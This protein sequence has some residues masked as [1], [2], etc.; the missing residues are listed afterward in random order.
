[1]P[2][3][4]DAQRRYFNANRAEL[5]AQG[6]DVDEW[7]SA[8]RGKKLPETSRGRK[9]K[10]RVK[11]AAVSGKS[12]AATRAL[13]ARALAPVSRLEKKAN[14]LL[15][16]ALQ[17]ARRVKQARLSGKPG[18]QQAA[19]DLQ[20]QV[21]LAKLAMTMGR[22]N[23]YC[24]G[25]LRGLWRARREHLAKQA[26]QMAPSMAAAGP[27]ADSVSLLSGQRQVGQLP[28]QG[29]MTTTVGGPGGANSPANNPIGSYGPLNQAGRMGGGALGDRVGESANLKT[30]NIRDTQLWRRMKYAAAQPMPKGLGAYDSA[31]GARIP[32]TDLVLQR[33]VQNRLRRMFQP[34]QAVGSLSPEELEALRQL[35]D[36]QMQ[37]TQYDDQKA[38]QLRDLQTRDA[39]GKD[40]IKL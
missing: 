32:G 23:Q 9:S 10:A 37:A 19:L 28:M 26:M 2:Y 35:E 20:K 17:E 8:S 3:S 11:R 24:V 33:L 27:A 13:L 4:S 14:A 39:A 30:A 7:N 36:W 12:T 40:Y 31:A 34:T 1:M 6:V 22:Q 15:M 16:P 29:S 21:A 5:T 18:P 38:K 25:P